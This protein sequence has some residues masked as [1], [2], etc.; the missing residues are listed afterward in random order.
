MQKQPAN[1]FG[2]SLHSRITRGQQV[3]KRRRQQ[4]AKPRTYKKRSTKKS[5]LE[6]HSQEGVDWIFSL[7][8]EMRTNIVLPPKATHSSLDLFE[9]P[10]LLVTFDQS[11]ILPLDHRSNSK[12]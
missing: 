10:P 3:F 9:K 7:E 11:F 4:Y 12:L 2:G 8:S 1:H 6:N 5:L